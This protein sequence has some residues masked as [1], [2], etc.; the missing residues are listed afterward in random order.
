MHVLYL[1]HRLFISFLNECAECKE[2]AIF[3]FFKKKKLQRLNL[4]TFA[5]RYLQD[6]QLL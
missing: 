2:D 5:A 4:S 3:I 1:T 6:Q